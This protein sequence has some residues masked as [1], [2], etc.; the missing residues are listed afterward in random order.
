MLAKTTRVFW[1]WQVQF[2]QLYPEAQFLRD[3]YWPLF[4]KGE[5]KE[6]F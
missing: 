2:F 4:D 1:F 3:F 6:E 5:Y